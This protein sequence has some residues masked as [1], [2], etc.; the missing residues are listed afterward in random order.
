[1]ATQA[2]TVV[3]RNLP[4]HARNPIHTDG[5]A[6]AAGFEQALV[7]GVTSYAYLCH[8]PIATWGGQWVAG[9][10]AEVRFRAP[11][12]DGELLTIDAMSRAP[13]VMSLELHGAKN[14]LLRAEATA[15]TRCERFALE[16]DDRWTKVAEPVPV[17]HVV[18]AGEFD[19]RYGARVGD[20][21][22]IGQ[23]VVHPAVWP[24]LANR[25][26]HD[27]VVDGP[28]IHTRSRIHHHSL[29]VDGEVA[30]V[31]ANVVGRR[32]SGRGDVAVLDVRIHVD[33]RPIASIEHEAIVR[34]SDSSAT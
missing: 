15:A 25:V 22:T 8:L 18:L 12:L 33:G 30:T 23:G 2:W 11:V 32:S 28:W 10:M 13:G 9:G 1:M 20:D 16:L 4:E 26:T 14:E 17:A 5:G 31:E 3:A 27:H 29:A 24:A 19:S 21:A 34:L 7:A 6:R